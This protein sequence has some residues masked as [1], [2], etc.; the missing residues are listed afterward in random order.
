MIVVIDFVVKEKFKKEDVLL[1]NVMI[2]HITSLLT[3]HQFFL[4]VNGNFTVAES[5]KN[6]TCIPVKSSGLFFNN[7]WHSIHLKNRLKKIKPDI[8]IN[9]GAFP[10]LKNVQ[11]CLSVPTIK[12]LSSYQLKH[13][14]QVQTIFAGSTFIRQE[15]INEYHIEANKIIVTF[16]APSASFQPVSWEEKEAIKSHFTNEA[17]FFLMNSI[18]SGDDFLNILK[19]FSLFKKRLQTNMKLLIPFQFSAKD[20][21]LSG[22]LANYKYKEDVLFTGKLTVEQTTQI[23]AAAYAVIHAANAKEEFTTTQNIIQ[24]C[25]P[26]LVLH[27]KRWKH[28]EDEFLYAPVEEFEEIAAK[29]M[30]LYKD[31]TYRN[32]IIISLQQL[33][34]SFS[35][36]AT[37]KAI[38]E[39]LLY[40][41][42]E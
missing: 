18:N 17:E 24:C 37:S 11:N 3:Q 6:V 10:I 42:A 12:S 21:Q 1:N 9:S 40:A 22:L 35:L 23:I 8:L 31:E 30:L 7:F 13:L 16:L 5:L 19:A 14:Q 4:V 39:R 20:K 28:T 38:C 26:I 41:V 27:P 29:L 34:P 32:R 33:L 15:L 36:M 2:E 25:V